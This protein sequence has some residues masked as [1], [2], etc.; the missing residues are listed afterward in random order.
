MITTTYAAISFGSRPDTHQYV[1]HDDRILGHIIRRADDSTRWAAFAYKGE[2][3]VPLGL[4]MT[5][6][7]AIRVVCASAACD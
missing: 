7:H 1:K 2:Q 6:D 5:H 3:T 4:A